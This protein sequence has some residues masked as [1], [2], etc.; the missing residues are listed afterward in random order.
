MSYLKEIN[1]MHHSVYFRDILIAHPVDIPEPSSTAEGQY[2]YFEL[3]DLQPIKLVL[4][5]MTTQ[6]VNADEKYAYY[7]VEYCL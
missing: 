3:L 1:K 2:V 6:H 7:D 5:F 4:S